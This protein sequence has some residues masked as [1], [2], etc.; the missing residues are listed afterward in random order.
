MMN[1][2]IKIESFELYDLP[3]SMMKANVSISCNVIGSDDFFE[4]PAMEAAPM[5][6]WNTNFISKSQGSKEVV[7]FISITRHVS[8]DNIFPYAQVKIEFENQKEWK[9]LPGGGRI[10][11]HSVIETVQDQQMKNEEE[12]Q[13]IEIN[14]LR[15]QKT[16]EQRNRE[17]AALLGVNYEQIELKALT[18]S[19]KMYSQIINSQCPECGMFFSSQKST[20]S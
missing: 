18:N 1:S 12:E 4:T 19:Q 3:Q 8:A 11:I 13:S 6:R 14:T 5:M 17:L 2:Q 7:F 9:N 15:M 16:R 20:Q 10:R